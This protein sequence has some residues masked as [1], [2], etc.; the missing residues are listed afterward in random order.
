MAIMLRTRARQLKR[1]YA[2]SATDGPLPPPSSSGRGGS[3]GSTQAKGDSSRNSTAKGNRSGW[4]RPAPLATAQTLSLFSASPEALLVAL[5]STLE[6]MLAQLSRTA[7]I[8]SSSSSGRMNNRVRDSGEITPA[9]TQSAEAD[10]AADQIE[11][12]GRASAQKFVLLFALS[13]DLPSPILS[14]AVSLLRG[15]SVPNSLRGLITHRIGT[16]SSGIPV[17]L[18]PSS[19]LDPETPVPEPRTTMHSVALSLLPT[20]NAIPFRST[21]RGK[22]A[23]QVGRWPEFKESWKGQRGKELSKA[24]D[25]MVYEDDASTTSGQ[26]KQTG[27][28]RGGRIDAGTPSTTGGSAGWKQIWGRENIKEEIP[29]SLR[30]LLGGGNPSPPQQQQHA[31]LSTILFSDP[32]P[33]GLLEGLDAHFGSASGIGLVAPPT[34]FETGR[35]QT[36]FYRIEDATGA[37]VDEIVAQGAVGIALVSPISSSDESSTVQPKGLHVAPKFE[38]LLSFGPRRPISVAR[39]NI[40]SQLGGENATQQFLRDLRDANAVMPSSVVGGSAAA[41]GGGKGKEQAMA[42]EEAR[43][44]SKGM[45]KE[46]EFYLGLYASEN[47][48]KVSHVGRSCEAFASMERALTCGARN[49]H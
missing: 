11:L 6:G 46:E 38:G 45:S 7:S 29:S 28:S 47:D 32:A 22:E 26:K 48:D 27:A 24:M 39:G 13:K 5:R 21:I 43:E 12:Q 40:I 4:N 2:T 19:V 1:A 49:S 17:S 8:K 18:L 25:Q 33:Q 44:I 15:S 30:D 35:A 20:S 9:Q 36:L 14:E 16:L 41:A 37:S 23:T 34:P 10:A 31:L 3:S 42:T